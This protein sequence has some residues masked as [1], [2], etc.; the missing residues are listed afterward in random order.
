MGKMRLLRCLYLFLLAVGCASPD[1]GLEEGGADAGVADAGSEAE[2]DAGGV[3]DDGY[4][5]A[6]VDEGFI[7]SH[8]QVVAA[9]GA[10]SSNV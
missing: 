3:C 6:V 8:P 9:W 5:P 4:L 2:Q 1:R 10:S 7:I